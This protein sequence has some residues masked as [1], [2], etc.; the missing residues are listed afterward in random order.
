M[1]IAGIMSLVQ[2]ICLPGYILSRLFQVK[3]F[4]KTLLFSFGLS[5]IANYL[6][7]LS[8]TSVGVYTQFALYAIFAIEV[9]IFLFLAYPI[10]NQPIANAIQIGGWSDFW[11]KYLEEIRQSSQGVVS[12][13]LFSILSVCA[14]GIAVFCILVY[15]IAFLVQ[16]GET[17]SWWDAVVSWDRWAVDWF[18]NRLP[19][20]TWHYPQL[21]PANWSLTY[22]FI[23]EDTVKFFAK[24]VMWL[25]DLGVILTGFAFG[26]V[27]KKIGPFIGIFFTSILLLRF[28]SRGS[29]YVDSALA[30]F[31]FLS[32]ACLYFAWEAGDSKT[33][34]ISI[35]LGAVF[36]SGAAVTKQGGLL[37]AFLYPILYHLLPRRAAT[38]NTW[39]FKR[40]LFAV[41]LI[42]L[43]L[44]APWYIYKEVNIQLGSDYSEVSTTTGSDHFGRDYPQRLMYGIGSIVTG[45]S[46]TIGLPGGL[47]LAVL[48]V[49][50]FASL[51]EP[52]CRWIVSLIILPFF[53]AWG[54]GF[55]YD[56]HN[57][58]MIIPFVGLCSGMGLENIL[59]AIPFLGRLK[60]GYVLAILLTGVLVLSFQFTDAYLLTHSIEKQKKIGEAG[61]NNMLYDYLH[62]RGL[63]GRILTDYSLLGFL[64]ELKDY[65]AGGFSKDKSFIQLS[66]KPEIGYVLINRGWASSEV[67]N[68][69]DA[70]LDQGDLKLVFR[71]MDW[72]LI[73]VAETSE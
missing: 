61:L 24:G 18:N 67:L 23:G 41:V 68:Y 30:F 3:G 17:F 44:I 52:D 10:L 20:R 35:L 32:F 7:V 31:A 49:L 51:K 9:V 13:R 40:I 59:R 26:V 60:A 15:L 21:I 46:F 1:F 5:T 11:R 56:T 19:D 58:P 47:F 34:R 64:P 27:R 8:L 48:A 16:F 37:I 12:R 69:F 65:S 33:E 43:L 2:M 70:K 4:W 42:Y 73:D 36:A 38:S 39:E 72:M 28:G 57:L 29:G 63:R 55:S 53:L 25:F 54:L 66:S 71:Y 62:T 45:L 50:L 22:K 14:V 6:I